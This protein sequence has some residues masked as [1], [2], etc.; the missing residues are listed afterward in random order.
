M[1]QMMMTVLT[2]LM[3][4][5]CVYLVWRFHRF[6]F[7]RRWAGER[8]WLAW[9]LAAVPLLLIAAFF[10]I[11]LYAVLIVWLHLTVILLLADLI[12]LVIRKIRRRPRGDTA[13]IIAVCFTVVY[14]AAGW[15][16]AH[17][18]F[19]T[20]YTF[21]TEKDLGAPRLRIVAIADSHLGITLSGEDFAAQMERVQQTQPD[22]VV[23][24]GDYVDDDTCKE[25]MIAACRALGELK[26]TYG[27]F[28]TYGNH[29]KGYFRYRDFSEQDLLEELAKNRVTV[30]R[31]EAVPLGEAIL[32]GR[33]DRSTAGRAEAAALTAGLDGSKYIVMLDHQPNDY[34]NEAAAGPDLVISGHTHGGHIW[35]AGYVGIWTGANDK[36]YGVE[37]RG[38]THFLV[39]SGI[40]GWGIP[41]K[42]GCISEF[43]VIDIEGD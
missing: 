28:F 31:D 38:N 23:I 18:V 35:P 19:E 36:T 33:Q 6:S 15:F 13:G 43:V 24:V 29:D 5:G 32:V 20:D 7:L 30:L 16:F 34:A 9:L 3:A 26:T 40:S 4:A 21:R 14:L 39:T 42:T 10:L 8:K 11:N 37:R 41:F 2:V 1:F 12:G 22:A 27:V 17:H 25:D